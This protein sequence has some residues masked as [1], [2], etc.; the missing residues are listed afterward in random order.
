MAKFMWNR[1]F[2]NNVTAPVCGQFYVAPRLVVNEVG[3][4][5]YAICTGTSLKGVLVHV[6]VVLMFH[7]FGYK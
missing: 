7:T 1:G 4:S 2:N 6:T 3:I 5:I